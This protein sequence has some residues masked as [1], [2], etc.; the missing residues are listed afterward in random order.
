MIFCSK[1]EYKT[2]IEQKLSS[3]F[4][5]TALTNERHELTKLYS[6]E[7]LTNVPTTCMSTITHM[8]TMRNF[9]VTTDKFTSLKLPL[10]TKYAETEIYE[11]RL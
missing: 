8:K 10:I 9:Q 2:P 6:Y 7:A 4:S 11:G 1:Y 5:L 3:N